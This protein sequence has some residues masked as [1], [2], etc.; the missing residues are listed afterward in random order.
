M[1][2]PPQPPRLARALALACLRGDAREVIVGDLDQEFAETVAAGTSH[3]RARRRYW[4]QALASIAATQQRPHEDRTTIR[5]GLHPWQGLSLDLRSVLRV[6]RR[7]PGYVVVAVLS[8]AIGIG[9]NTAVFS[10]VRQLLLQPL[11]V[12]RPD[13]LRLLWW[14]PNS[15]E[16][17]NISNI[18]STS[19]RDAAGGFYRSNFSYPEV[20]TMRAAVSELADLCGFNN[21]P[22]GTMSVDG[23][24]PVVGAVLLVSG[25]F[26]ATIRP[27]LALGR[28]LTDADDV[29]GAPATAV[30]GYGLWTR[31]FGNDP[32]V[33]GK[34]I[35]VNGVP[36]NIVGVTGAEFRG[37]SPGGYVAE[38][39]VTLTLAQQPAIMPRRASPGESL[40]TSGR[41]Y[42]VRAIVRVRNGNDDAI[43][44]VLQG[45]LRARF[46]SGGLTAAQ[47]AIATPRLFPGARGVDSV[48]T[49][50]ILPL[51]ILSIVVG[52]VLLIACINVA[53]LM[54]ARAVSRQR[55]ISVRR[56][57]GAGRAR[58][59]RQLLLESVILSLAGG[60]AGLLLALAMAPALQSMLSSGFGTNGIGLALDWPLLGMT[61]ALACTAGVL[62]GLLPAIRFSRNTDA[63][64]KDRSGGAGAPRLMVGRALL[65]LQIAVSL[66]LVAGAGLFLRT[67]HNLGSLELGFNPHGLV[68]FVIDPTMGGRAPERAPDIYPR[69]L[70]R[71]EAIPGV[72]SATLVENALISGWESDSTVTVNGQP[73]HMFM[74]AVGPHYLETMEV[75]LLA[76]RPIGPDDTLGLPYAVVLNQTAAHKFFGAASPVGQRF[77]LGSREVEVVGVAADTK[78][79]GLRN[80]IQPTMLQSYLQRQKG[81]MHVAVRAEVPVATLRPAIERAVQD[82]DPRLPITEFKTQD[83]Q[84]DESI[85]KERVFARLLTV[86]GLFALLLAC[87]G[88]HGVTSY[89]VA[90]RTSEIGIRLALGAQRSHVL[91]LV[92]RQVVLLAAIGLAIGLPAAW[93]AGPAV[94]S[95]LFGLEPGDP[96]TIVVSAAIMAGVAV[97]AG[98][99]PARRAARMEA[100]SALRSE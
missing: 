53:G 80:D 50:A 82:V 5:H 64:L 40:F 7:S 87:V 59:M 36:V 58:I 4:R 47:A 35:S 62:A 21:A 74:N 27:P 81:S 75:P 17:L 19:Y 97:A 65:V 71:L 37:L 89:S 57:L 39:D 96:V 56:A 10:V 77:T 67:I 34:T 45:T 84:I 54:L 25:N 48:R 86:F 16:P 41:D 1:T 14:N 46:V 73:G 91:W 60:L 42:W 95:F 29:V 13:D 22:G 61:A 72:T 3:G 31:L 23:R 6:L 83:Q 69:L 98:L 93:L 33:V 52:V 63:M 8:L 76:G 51:R 70:A 88:L 43:T 26:F 30:I 92:L 38:P 78:Y 11:P 24:P 20:V 66:P 2:Q 55:E 49:S 18:N 85:G 99:W 79:D 90:R 100:L 32:T 94:R 15:T 28:S 12:E 68:L 44:G 9:A